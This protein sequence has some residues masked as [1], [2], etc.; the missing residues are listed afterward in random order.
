MEDFNQISHFINC[1]V[2]DYPKQEGEEEQIEQNFNESDPDQNDNLFFEKNDIT[3]LK[4]RKLHL[5]QFK[6]EIETSK[7]FQ[8]K[9]SYV[10]N[11]EI[12]YQLEH[13]ANNKIHKKLFQQSKQG[14]Q[15]NQKEQKEKTQ[16]IKIRTK[17]SLQNIL[18]SKKYYEF[19]NIL[20]NDSKNH[21]QTIQKQQNQKKKQYVSSMYI[22]KLSDYEDTETFITGQGVQG[23]TKNTNTQDLTIGRQQSINI[24]Q[25]TI[26]PNDITPSADE[27]DTDISR[28]HCKIVYRTFIYQKEMPYGGLVYFLK[29][30]EN[31]QKKFLE[32]KEKGDQEYQNKYGTLFKIGN[33]ILNYNFI[34]PILQEFII[35]KKT[36]YLVDFKSQN[37]TKVQIHHEQYTR[38][39]SHM[40][41]T[42]GVNSLIYF[43]QINSYEYMNRFEDI[44]VNCIYDQI[45][46]NYE[47]ETKKWN[48]EINTCY[49]GLDEETEEPEIFK[50]IKQV[51]NYF[52]NIQTQDAS[53]ENYFF[54]PMYKQ[55]VFE[56]IKELVML[57]QEQHQKNLQD[58]PQ[59]QSLS[60]EEKEKIPKLFQNYRPYIRALVKY[61]D[62]NPHMIK[63]YYLFYNYNYPVRVFKIGRLDT[64]HI[65]IRFRH[66]S[67]KNSEIVYK[68]NKW[69]IRDGFDDSKNQRKPSTEKTWINITGF[70]N[71][72]NFVQPDILCVYNNQQIFQDEIGPYPIKNQDIIMCGKSQKFQ[73]NYLDSRLEMYDDQLDKKM[74]S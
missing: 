10:S 36:A 42:I 31:F 30:L 54:Q 17:T 1:E 9:E 7:D 33:Y 63:P 16:P 61:D 55:P 37:G 4:G 46:L 70:Q 72:P 34:L 62:C 22:L 47:I 69:L 64:N 53:F 23:S 24:N 73:I 44:I 27:T 49:F 20:I 6:M 14:H 11:P 12:N 38:L 74:H 57:A 35:P 39:Y 28:M 48:L 15:G 8:I 13:H 50:I 25:E 43:E 66:V 41:I 19:Q 32:K 29:I 52:I 58:D 60:K 18:D 59:Y 65:Q 56:K 68:N 45:R 5:Q 3:I 2:G 40:I 51:M 67:R 71:Q 21:Y 26:K